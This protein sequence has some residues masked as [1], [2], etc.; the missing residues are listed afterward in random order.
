MKN[1]FYETFGIIHE[2]IL[3]FLFNYSKIK[4]IKEYEML[5]L[6]EISL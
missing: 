3:R 1:L 6:P 4:Y 2:E 5:N